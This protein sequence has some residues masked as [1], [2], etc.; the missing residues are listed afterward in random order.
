MLPPG[1]QTG[2]KKNK[3]KT[4]HDDGS[5]ASVGEKD[6]VLVFTLHS[7]T[8]TPLPVLK[9]SFRIPVQRWHQ[10][11]SIPRETM[12]SETIRHQILAAIDAHICIL[13]DSGSNAVT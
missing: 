10:Q 8:Y 1:F 3:N 6:F 11:S 5:A 2:G 4:K 9:N 13:S 7:L 12:S